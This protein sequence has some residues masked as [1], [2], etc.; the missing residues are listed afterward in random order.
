MCPLPALILGSQPVFH[1]CSRLNAG[2]CLHPFGFTVGLL[3]TRY[4]KVLGG[5]PWKLILR[6]A[7][8]IRRLST[9]KETRKAGLNKGEADQKLRLQTSP[10]VLD[11]GRPLRVVLNWGKR[12]RSFYPCTYQSLAIPL[13]KVQ[14][15]QSRAVPGNYPSVICQQPM[16]PRANVPRSQHSQQL[17][18]RRVGPEERLCLGERSL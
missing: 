12:A 4:L 15:G 2:L 14:L 10:G 16:F 17:E 9:P 5:V 3:H 7:W 1:E 8:L 6:G 13:G 11:L 18:D